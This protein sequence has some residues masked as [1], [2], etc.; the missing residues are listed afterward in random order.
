MESKP[1]YCLYVRS[2]KNGGLLACSTVFVNTYKIP[3]CEKLVWSFVQGMN[4]TKQFML[5][6]SF[7]Q[8]NI[9][10]H[11][12]LYSLKNIFHIFTQPAASP[13]ESISYLSV[14]RSCEKHTPKSRKFNVLP[15]FTCGKGSLVVPWSAMY[16]L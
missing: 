8:F 5:P 2:V 12:N 4:L 15:N 10:S 3:Y 16:A 11:P 7:T 13:V 9:F 1:R 6:N 14:P